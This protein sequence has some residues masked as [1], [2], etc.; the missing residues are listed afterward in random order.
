[1]ETGTAVLRKQQK[2]LRTEEKE[3]RRAEREAGRRQAELDGI[4]EYRLMRRKQK[5]VAFV[6][7]AVDRAVERLN[8]NDGMGWQVDG[9]LVRV[10]QRVGP[11]PGWQCIFHGR[12]QVAVV[13]I[14]GMSRR[15]NRSYG[16]YVM[17]YFYIGSDGR[18]YRDGRHKIY[19]VD[20]MERTWPSEIRAVAEH[21][22]HIC[23]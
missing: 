23:A 10:C 7:A 9:K 16:R 8:Q 11:H 22:D 18:V 14:P 1:M 19:I 2:M 15:E 6:H 3:R 13:Q 5:A 20:L 4:S 21:I 12:R 17:M